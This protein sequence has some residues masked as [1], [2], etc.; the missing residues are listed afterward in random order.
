MYGVWA[1]ESVQ[2]PNFVIYVPWALWFLSWLGA[3][4]VSNA[5]K[6]LT[7]AQDVLYRM[8][9]IIGTVTLLFGFLPDPG[10]DVRNTLWQPLDGT[11]GWILLTVVVVAFLFAWWARICL[12]FSLPGSGKKQEPFVEAG[13]YK[14]VRHPIY[15]S[16]IIAAFA[17]ALM[18]GRPS[19]LGGA[20]LLTVAFVLKILLQEN[21][22]HA[23]TGAFE[24][25]AERVPM[26]VPFVNRLF[27]GERSAAA[28]PQMPRFDEQKPKPALNIVPPEMPALEDAEPAIP[29]PA[30]EPEIEWAE[31]EVAEAVP[32]AAPE[33]VAEAVP[34]PVREPVEPPA[35]VPLQPEL[36]G[37]SEAIS[38]TNR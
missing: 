26:L 11:L 38:I 35:K 17:T 36:P 23:E 10:F 33:P 34:P 2:Q 15:A 6:R 18:F 5:K 37:F 1:E 22:L 31:P 8:L 9:V 3:A 32:L 27:R 28:V 7:L 12:G 25:Y 14:W 20:T 21:A 19:C 29:L 24:D 16:L 13:P 4:L 30:D